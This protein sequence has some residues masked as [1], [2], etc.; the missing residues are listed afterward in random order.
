MTFLSSQ[1]TTREINALLDSG[2]NAER[3]QDLREKG[4]GRYN[5]GQAEREL[6]EIMRY[7]V[8]DDTAKRIRSR[9]YLSASEI[10]QAKPSFGVIACME[11]IQAASL[12][13]DDIADNT[14]IR[15]KKK[16]TH[17]QFGK[18][19]AELAALVLLEYAKLEIT[20]DRTFDDK[21]KLA[22]IDMA[23]GTTLQLAIGQLA[24]LNPRLM[25]IAGKEIAEE[26]LI[27]EMVE[28]KTG[29]LFDFPLT[30]AAICA[31]PKLRDEQVA[32][33]RR[34]GRSGIGFSLQVAE[35]ILD[36]IQDQNDGKITLP[37][38]IGET[39]AIKCIEERLAAESSRFRKAF[40]NGTDIGPLID[41]TY[42]ALPGI[43]RHLG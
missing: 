25:K 41:M 13:L 3:L 8:L 15:R 33:M 36:V 5:L 37:I 27:I 16:A 43:R 7:A 2:L 42:A 22:L 9:F 23:S 18:D 6:L 28:N 34:F 32:A 39:S 31:S 1:I 10:V 17:I 24:D 20:A 12:I 11:Y 4:A 30:A 38:V 21:Q 19:N 35:D 40:E 14:E 29:A 26:S